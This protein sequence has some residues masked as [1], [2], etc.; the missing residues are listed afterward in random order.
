MPKNL[1]SVKPHKK[2]GPPPEWTPE[3][4][5]AAIVAANGL[6]THAAKR[7]GCAPATVVKYCHEHPVCQAARKEADERVLDFAEGKLM[8][9]INAGNITANIFFLKCKGKPRGYTE[10]IHVT[11]TPDKVFEMRWVG[12]DVS[13][14]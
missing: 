3:E 9:A 10:Q 1:K 4:M 11:Q 14:E 6:V 8:E 2:P 5:A 12:E 7:L 13:D